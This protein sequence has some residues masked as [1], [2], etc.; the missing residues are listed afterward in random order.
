MSHSVKGGSTYLARRVFLGVLKIP[1]DG[2]LR[3]K[4]QRELVSPGSLHRGGDMGTPQGP[5]GFFLLLESHQGTCILP[6]WGPTQPE[7]QRQART[8]PS[9]PGRSSQGAAKRPR[10]FHLQASPPTSPGA[11]WIAQ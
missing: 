11:P 9:G 2:G 8:W 10:C 5:L 3:N 1:G 6:H 4:A 7:Q